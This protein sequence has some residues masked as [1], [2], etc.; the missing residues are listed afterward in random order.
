M[1]KYYYNFILNALAG[2]NPDEYFQEHREQILT[3]T[4]Y[5]QEKLPVPQEKVYRGILLD[6]KRDLVLKPIR[7]ITYISFSTDINVARS[8]A[9]P[10]HQMAAFFRIKHPTY[11]GYLIEHLPEPPTHGQGRCR[12]KRFLKCTA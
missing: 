7:H 4:R 5:L 11:E 9:D 10:T 3:V 6:P 8:F 1:E 2:T 12:L